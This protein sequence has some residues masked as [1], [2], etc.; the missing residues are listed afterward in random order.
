MV[1][2]LDDF[3]R[4]SRFLG[5]TKGIEKAARRHN[6]IKAGKAQQL[7]DQQLF[8]LKR[9]QLELDIQ[10]KQQTGQISEL[11][12][13]TQK[14]LL[15][16]LNKQAQDVLKSR[17]TQ[18]N[19]MEDKSM[20][21]IDLLTSSAED[22]LQDP[23][24]QQALGNMRSISSDPVERTLD[25]ALRDMGLQ[26]DTNIEVPG[27]GRI[28]NADNPKQYKQTDTQ[29]FRQDAQRFLTGELNEKQ[30]RFLYPESKMQEEI[31]IL[32]SDSTPATRNP[33]FKEGSGLEAYFSKD[34]AKI[35]PELRGIISQIKTEDDLAF[36]LT[37]P[38]A[39]KEMQKAGINLNN[40]DKTLAEVFDLPE[41]LTEGGL[42]QLGDFGNL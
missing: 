13:E 2:E 22:Y 34:V 3:R 40:L 4:A 12:A 29:K 5:I 24:N 7:Q 14:N 1:R 17:K 9:K 31:D 11:A 10:Q 25:G 42:N 41:D 33:N 6:E 26:F 27:V 21:D 15:N 28:R 19:T 35:T 18:L 39:R 30:L 36:F 38:Q 37:D 16:A 32:I 23:A 20:K 8:D